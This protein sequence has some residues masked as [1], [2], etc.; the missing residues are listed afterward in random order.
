M[1][2]LRIENSLFY[3][4]PT[5]PFPVVSEFWNIKSFSCGSVNISGR[6]S[7]LRSYLVGPQHVCFIARF[8]EV[9]E[10]GMFPLPTLWD[11]TLILLIEQHRI[12]HQKGERQGRR[13]EKKDRGDGT[14]RKKSGQGTQKYSSFKCKSRSKWKMANGSPFQQHLNFD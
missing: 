1:I 2:F 9:N 3:K 13:S 12:R 7:P 14:D 4:T 6:G 5:S 8:Q 10:M 11:F